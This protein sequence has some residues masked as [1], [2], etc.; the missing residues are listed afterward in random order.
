MRI[1]VLGAGVAGVATAWQLLKD[2]HQ[3][4]VIDR[5]PGPAQFTSFA[6]LVRAHRTGDDAALAV[7]GRSGD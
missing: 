7:A 5:A 6:N 4:T 3:V 1:V 2:G